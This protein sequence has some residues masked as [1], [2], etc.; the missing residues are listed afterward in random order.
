MNPFSMSLFTVKVSP[1]QIL[2][3][4]SRVFPGRL[5]V[6]RSFGDVEA[7]VPKFG[8]N[9]NVIIAHPEVQ[10]FKIS[11]DHDFLVL[12]CNRINIGDGIYD[13]TSNEDIVE[14]IW[15][16]TKYKREENIHI[17]AGVGVDMILKTSLAKKSLDN[18]TCV[19]LVFEGF[20]FKFLND[21]R[22]YSNESQR[23]SSIHK[24]MNKENLIS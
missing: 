23:V 20:E 18:I 16:P 3:G 6:S 5:S 2:T 17:Q 7:K 10:V 11:E 1:N 22:K 19:L 8:G 9:P 21:A 24:R 4:P 13:Q 15:L 12:G 14:C